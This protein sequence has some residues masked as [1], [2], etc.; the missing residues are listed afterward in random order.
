MKGAFLTAEDT[1]PSAVGTGR[2]LAQGMGL[3]FEEGLQGS[4]GE[5]GGRGEGDLLHGGE[6]DV[7]SRP[8]VPVGASGDN[9]APL[10][11][12]V[13]EFLE[14]FGSEGATCHD[15]SCLGVGTKTKEKVDHV[16]LWRRT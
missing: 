6:I 7:E 11:G 10:G 16:R 2:L 9:F 14:F 13:V 1:R 5:T 15:A 3:L 12:E 4:L 8:L